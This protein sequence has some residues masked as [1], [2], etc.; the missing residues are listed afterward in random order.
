MTGEN[1][2]LLYEAVKME[3]NMCDLYL[4]YRDIFSRDSDFWTQLA[5]EEKGHAA[6]LELG[7]EVGD[8]LPDELLCGKIADMNRMNM[9]MGNIIEKFKKEAPSVEDACK[10]AIEVENSA[11]ELH[12]QHLA[13]LG[14]DSEVIRRFQK[15]NGYDKDHAERIAAFLADKK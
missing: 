1:D 12:Y 14:A 10:Y 6:L 15:L 3:L 7:R 13:S 9:D 4:L 8:I 5:K 2:K 11:Y